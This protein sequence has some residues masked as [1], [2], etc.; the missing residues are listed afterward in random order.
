MRCKPI[1]AKLNANKLNNFHQQTRLY[2]VAFVESC[3]NITID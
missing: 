2:T 3:E 1:R